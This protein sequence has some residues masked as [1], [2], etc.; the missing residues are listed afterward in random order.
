MS[1]E[2]GETKSKRKRQRK[3]DNGNAKNSK[4]DTTK[5]KLPL[6]G[7][8]L[9]ISTLDVKGQEHENRDLSYK[10]ISKLCV[11]LGAKVAAQ[12]HKKV[13]ALICTTTSLQNATQRV[14]KA[15]KHDIPLVD[16]T[17]LYECQKD[18]TDTGLQVSFQDYLL[19]KSL[20]REIPKQ[21]GGG[22]N[23]DYE[24]IPD[25]GWTEAED[26]GCC[27]VC[28][29]NGSGDVCP[30]CTDCTTNTAAARAKKKQKTTE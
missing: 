25:K 12:V 3:N 28:H 13:S 11:E 5:I 24:E 1:S 4:N 21:G 2:G 27:C 23:P 19:D 15:V 18:K 17:W 20:V 10:S 26:L 7:L 9:A 16:V 29:E 22:M 8:T 6:V 30:W 14:R